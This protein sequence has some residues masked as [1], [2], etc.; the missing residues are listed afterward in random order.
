MY[1]HIHQ[2]VIHTNIITSTTDNQ[3]K[4]IVFDAKVVCLVLFSLNSQSVLNQHVTNHT[5]NSCSIIILH[6]NTNTPAT[7]TVITKQQPPKMVW[8]QHKKLQF[9]K[10]PLKTGTKTESVPKLMFTAWCEKW[11]WYIELLFILLTAIKGVNLYISHLIE[12]H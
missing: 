2:E 10:L 4:K 1:S 12:L 5:D 9:L 6:T 8:S 3:I 7:M 11:F